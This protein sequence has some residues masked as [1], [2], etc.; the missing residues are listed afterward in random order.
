M[1]FVTDPL[2]MQSNVAASGH[3]QILLEEYRQLYELVRFRLAA[4]DQRVPLAGVALIVAIS[5]TSTL[6]KPAQLVL[7]FALPLS[8]LWWLGMTI[9]HARS[10]EDALRRIEEIEKQINA[11]CSV[12]LLKFQSSHPGRAQVGGRTGQQTV[13]AVLAASAIILGASGALAAHSGFTSTWITAYLVGLAAIA[14]GLLW[15]ATK[16]RKYSTHRSN[17][18]GYVPSPLP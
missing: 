3:V 7:L 8:L 12:E 1:S 17:G 18:Q 13:Q 14:S 11:L 5:G 4:L 2:S 10:F 9:T 15:E 6:P 16:L